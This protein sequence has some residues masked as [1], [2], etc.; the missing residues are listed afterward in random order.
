MYSRMY[1]IYMY[2]YIFALMTPFCS[3]HDKKQHTC[4]YI[5]IYL[6]QSID[7]P[8]YNRVRFLNRIERSSSPRSSYE[9]VC[10]PECEIFSITKMG[11]F[12]NQQKEGTNMLGPP[13][14]PVIV[15]KPSIIFKNFMKG[16]I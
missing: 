4:I 10:D 14:N 11:G 2:I 3:S 9:E 8:V 12:G 7:R 6:Q 13:P 1:I 16:P 5:Y 15:D